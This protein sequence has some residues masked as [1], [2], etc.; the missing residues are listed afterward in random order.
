MQIFDK[1]G[2]LPAEMKTEIV[3]WMNRDLDWLLTSKLGMEA[4]ALPQNHANWYNFQVVGL[5]LYLGRID[6]AKT[7]I[8]DAKTSRIAA[9]IKPDGRQPKEIGRSPKEARR[10]QS[11]RN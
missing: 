9:Q 1:E 6:E 7:R 8:E 10:K 11:R 4:D 2:V 3:T 5:M